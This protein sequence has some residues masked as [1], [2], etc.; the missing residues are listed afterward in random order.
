MKL[1]KLEAKFLLNNEVKIFFDEEVKEA[2]ESMIMSHLKVLGDS[3]ALR[4][5]PD[6]HS[7]LCLL[8]VDETTNRAIAY[9]YFYIEPSSKYCELFATYVSEAYRRRGVAKELFHAA[10]E[11]GEKEGCT[12]FTI[13]FAEPNK[14]RAGLME[15]YQRYLREQDS[16]KQ[17]SIYYGGK[18][19]KFPAEGG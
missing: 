2:M 18:Q 11:R 19:Y 4:N 8:A 6:P 13:R 5:M 15:Y 1:I 14:E 16:S 7:H 12:H 9:R 10:V 17:F 3:W